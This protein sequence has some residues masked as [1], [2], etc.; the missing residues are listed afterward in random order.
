MLGTIVNTIAIIVGSLVGLGFR[1]GIPDKY[2]ATTIHAI[3]MAVILVG[4]KS[5]LKT[6]ALLVVIFSMAVGSVV[7]ERLRIE[8]RLEALGRW[9]EGR[10]A[11]GG[12]G[13]ANGFVTASLIYCVGAMAI[14]GSLESGL[15]GNHQTLFAKSVL[16]GITA[17]IFAATFGVG[18]MFSAVSVLVYQGA[19]TAAAGLL[20]PLLVPSVVAQMSSVGGLL[21]M[22]IGF[23]LF[24]VKKIRVGNML[25]AI[26]LPMVWFLV[27]QVLPMG[28]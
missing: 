4:L 13:I 27:Q 20:Q 3:A 7:G 24:E 17:V 5:A 2:A 10:F 1:G 9:I 14:V 26:F 12:G 15:T 11:H 22:V 8:A 18:V 21:I 16:D 25:P 6:D 28:R 19:I 23:N